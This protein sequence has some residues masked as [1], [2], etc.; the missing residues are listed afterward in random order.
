M[1]LKLNREKTRILNLREAG[2]GLDFLG[3]TFRYDRSL[4]GEGRYVNLFPSAK[5]M[6]RKREE[7]RDLTGRHCSPKLIDLIGRLNELLISGF[8]YYTHGYPSK[9]FAS[10]DWFVQVRLRRFLRNRSQRKM[11]IPTGMTQYTWLASL[12]LL[13]LS[14]PTVVRYLRGQGDLPVVCRRAGCGKSARPVR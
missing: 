9:A 1:G 5:A 2:R 6:A 3:Y 8:R 14:D 11:R 4:K 12:G 10:M 7:I 13:R